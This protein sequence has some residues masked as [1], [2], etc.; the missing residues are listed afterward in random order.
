MLFTVDLMH[1]RSETAL[2]SLPWPALSWYHHGVLFTAF[3]L[4]LSSS[5]ALLSWSFDLWRLSLALFTSIFLEAGST[6]VYPWSVFT[7]L[8]KQ[9]SQCM[10]FMVV[11]MHLRSETAELRALQSLPWPAL[12]WYHHGV[13]FTA[14]PL[15]LSSSCALH[16]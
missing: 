2:Q 7:A 8:S 13:L 1:L 11:S 16:S 10:L 4:Q 9:L 12:S 14:F 5:C 3:P 15:Q 6:V